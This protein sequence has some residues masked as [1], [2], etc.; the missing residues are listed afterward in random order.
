MKDWT[1]KEASTI[2]IT[3][4]KIQNNKAGV[5]NY[6]KT[7]IK[8]WRER[9]WSLGVMHYSDTRWTESTAD[10][11]G[12][13]QH[14]S[15]CTLRSEV[16]TETQHFSSWQCHCYQPFTKGPLNNHTGFLQL[17][18]HPQ[19]GGIYQP[20]LVPVPFLCVGEVYC[21]IFNVCFLLCKAIDPSSSWSKYSKKSCVHVRWELL[22][23]SLLRPV[24]QQEVHFKGAG[25]GSQLTED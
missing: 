17:P 2:N 5:L 11:G 8:Q 23:G 19:D 10:V 21:C 9:L 25:E 3:G 18:L 20:A 7:A 14:L 12:F 4:G 16:A 24:L 13:K 1:K 22:H 6:S 15:H